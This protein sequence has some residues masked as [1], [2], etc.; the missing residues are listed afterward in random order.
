MNNRTQVFSAI[1]SAVYIILQVL[2]PV[3][4]IVGV[5]IPIWQLFIPTLVMILPY[6]L[7][8]FYC[9][10]TKAVNEYAEF[11]ERLFKRR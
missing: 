10:L 3:L 9:W 5:N 11:V 1:Y 4:R 2:L 8:L 7:F 6:V